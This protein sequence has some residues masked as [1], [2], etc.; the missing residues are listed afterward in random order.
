MS[1]F[2]RVALA[3]G[4]GGC[5]ACGHGQYW[6]VVWGAGEDE[7]QIGT[8]WGDKEVAE[9]I[10]DLMNMAFEAGKESTEGQD[11]G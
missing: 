9:D 11:H 5:N 10:C 2:Y 6:S 8:S 3:D 1:D 7:C 4:G